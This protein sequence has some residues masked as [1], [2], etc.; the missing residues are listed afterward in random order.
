[1]AKN[2]VG[3]SAPVSA[4]ITVFVGPS[5]P[6]A[7]D[8]GNTYSIASGNL[9]VR[10]TDTVNTSSNNVY[11]WYSL[12]G[13]EYIH[14]NVKSDGP[15]T[16]S[17]VFYLPGLSNRDYTL[18]LIARNTVGSSTAN[19]I[20]KRIYTT[21]EFAP[22]IDRANTLSYSA[23]YMTVTFDDVS[24]NPANDIRYLYYLYDT[25]SMEPNQSGDIAYYQDSTRTLLLNGTTHYSFDVSGLINTTYTLYL[26]SKNTVGISSVDSTNV[27][28]YSIP[29]IPAID[30]SNTLSVASGNVLV[31]I[32]DT[33]NVSL[34]DVYYWYSNDGGNT[35]ANTNI[36]NLGPSSSSYQF[37]VSGLLN[38]TYTWLIMAKN[39]VGNAISSP[40]DVISYTK[41]YAVGFDDGNT[42]SVASGNLQVVMVDTSNISLNSVYYQYSIDGGNTF[43][44]TNIQSVGPSGS[45]Y[46]FWITDLSNQTYTVLVK[47]VNGI[48]ESVV[49]SISKMVYITPEYSP[50]VDAGNTLSATSGNLTVAFDDTSNRLSNDIQY[51]YYLYDPSNNQTQNDWMNP[52][53]YTYSGQSLATNGLGSTH[54]TFELSNLTNKIYTIYLLSKNTVGF[55]GTPVYANT[56]VYTTPEHPPLIDTANT[57]TAA[58]G[59]LLVS[60]TDGINVSLNDIYYWYST[61][62]GSSYANSFVKN[63]GPDQTAYSFYIPGLTNAN[64][65]LSILSKNTVGNS[66]PSTEPINVYTT[67]LSIQSI[68]AGNT[69]TVASGNVQVVFVDTNNTS[70]NDVYYWYS[71]Y[72]SVDGESSYANSFV[73]NAGPAQSNYM[74]YIEGLTNSHTA[75]SI[76]ARNSTDLYIGESASVRA[77]VSV[78]TTPLS[79]SSYSAVNAVSGNIQVSVSD[80]DNISTNEVYYYVYYYRSGDTGAN[81]SATISVYSN[82]Y[83]KRTDASS[84]TTFYLNDLSNNEYTVY[85]ATKNSVGSNLFSPAISPLPV[86]ITP[87]VPSIDNGNTLSQSS[88]NLTV[89]FVDTVN[90]STNSVYYWYS[91]NGGIYGNTGIS[92]T[93]GV[94]RYSYDLPTTQISNGNVYIVRIQTV[95]PVGQSATVATSNPIEVFTTPEIPVLY[96][97]VSQDTAIDV[98]FSSPYNNGNAISR[99]EYILNNTTTSNTTIGILTTTLVNSQNTSRISGLTNGHT[100]SVG[101]RAVNARGPS[102]WSSTQSTIPFGVPLIPDVNAVPSESAIDIYFT[103]PSSNGNAISRYEYSLTGGSAPINTIDLASNNQYRVSGLTN[104][105]TYSVVVRAVNTRGAGPWSSPATATPFTNP[106]APIVNLEALSGAF[107]IY[108]DTPYGGGVPISYYQYTLNNGDSYT[109]FGG[110]NNNSVVVSGINGT[111]YTVRVRTFNVNNRFSTLSSPVSVTPY[112]VP[113]SP[114]LQTAEAGIGAIPISFSPSTDNGGNAITRYEYSTNAGNS[115]ATMGLPTTVNGNGYI[116]YEITYQST[117]SGTTPLVN[118]TAYT[119]QLRAVN[120]RGPSTTS[121]GSITVI[122]FNR[123]D[124]PTLVSAI[125]GNSLINMTFTAPVSDGG[126][127]IIAYEYSINAGMDYQTIPNIDISAQQI[128]FTVSGLEN[129]NVF[130]VS[131]RCRNSRGLSNNSNVIE[132]I[133]FGIP[134]PPVISG[135]SKDTRIDVSFYTPNRRGSALVAYE[136]W[137]SPGS[138]SYK[139]VSSI[140]PVNDMSQNTFTIYGLTNGQTYTINVRTVN[141]VG[142]SATVSNSVR[143][144]PSTIPEAPAIQE[145]VSLPGAADIVIEQ[146][147]NTGGSTSTGYKYA[148][149]LVGETQVSP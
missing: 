51:W 67:P 57:R 61:N 42:Y 23:N 54:F 134:D 137:I 93:S 3:N 16:S 145:A 2:A 8:S 72:S 130:S 53:A 35:F 100:Y 80:P 92:K 109:Q 55:S 124:P 87:L 102:D 45:P 94:S 4:D 99:Y 136:Y 28:V 10:F 76:K 128:Q 9:Q 138:G 135:V 1:M 88:G 85:V 48:D 104:G 73:K 66:N 65:T 143:I 12:D 98:V 86:Y 112:G 18:S 147:A 11:Y 123:P 105:I 38:Q 19:T 40:V 31:T 13:G 7:I 71:T 95:N 91:I 6:P 36:L 78:Y 122:P 140:L 59:N 41:P 103:T 108:F 49:S 50:V 141:G 68:D 90:L 118:G 32:V 47:G 77:N 82:T 120:A 21:P 64:T 132:A 62:G 29:A 106:N 89:S 139:R 63:A 70:T 37:Y 142:T 126:S 127:R 17:Y 39:T 114:I 81:N 115:F 69:K 75:I 5:T 20:V 107:R 117:D 113:V 33:S 125:P 27:V 111:S 129:G 52:G 56:I 96:S 110:S 22:V 144:A 43:A 97:V 34:N 44:N 79:L 83:T 46:V 25:N 58:T 30:V 121:S 15:A 148:F 74:F 84:T 14:S 146:V 131:V 101:V 24:N 116:T 133:P 26:L 60:F 119:I 149:Y